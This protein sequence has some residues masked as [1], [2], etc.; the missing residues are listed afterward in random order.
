MDPYQRAQDVL[1]C[2]LCDNCLSEMYCEDCHKYL[3]KACLSQ[4]IYDEPKQ[5]KVLPFDKRDSTLSYPKCPKHSIKECGFFCRHCDIPVCD[6][7][8]YIQ[9]NVHDVVD[10]FEHFKSTNGFTGTGE[11]ILP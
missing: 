8:I 5:H 6:R 2:Q 10:I 4:H 7:C 11:I 9:H 3:C 1:Q